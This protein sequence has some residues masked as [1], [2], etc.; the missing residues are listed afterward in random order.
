MLK[1]LYSIGGLC[2]SFLAGKLSGQ[3]M[4]V[5]QGPLHCPRSTVPE[6]MRACKF[7]D[8]ESKDAG[9]QMVVRRAREKANSAKRKT[10]PPFQCGR[11]GDSWDDNHVPNDQHCCHQRQL[12]HI[13]PIDAD[14]ARQYPVLE[15]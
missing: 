15:G 12:N 3:I 8:K 1:I 7:S 4:V 5:P 14:D 10:P 13:A 9:K 2:Q 11:H 6:A